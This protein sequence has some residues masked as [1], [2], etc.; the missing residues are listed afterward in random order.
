VGSSGINLTNYNHNHNGAQ[1]VSPGDAIDQQYHLCTSAPNP[2]CNTVGNIPF[3]TPFVGYEPIGL[4]ASDWDGSSNYNSLQITVRHQFSH[5]LSLQGAY[6]WDR[7]LSDVFFGNSANINDALVLR[8]RPG[9]N[10]PKTGQWG[11]VSFDRY[12][13][14]VVNYSYDLPFGHGTQGLENKVIGGWNVAGVTIAQSGN[15]LTFIGGGTGGAYGTNQQLIFQGVTT[16]QFCPGKGNGDIKTP[17]SARSNLNDYFQTTT[18]GC[19]APLV[20]FGGPGATD[21]G[22]SAVG[23]ATGPGQWNWD[24]SIVK[25]TQITER[26]RMQ[27]RTD[28]YNAFNHPQFAP[29]QGGSFGTI[30][31]INVANVTPGNVG[32]SITATTV[33]PRLIQFGLHFFF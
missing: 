9:L 5:G 28:F 12:Q 29:P 7:N 4:Q 3:R 23:I 11:P 13:R 16:A 15:P 25:N 24:I 30:G 17:G 27:F 2:I 18:F 33:N 8:G 1:T 22:N 26:V 31:F 20:P 19:P 21:Y 32:N 10:G 6:T 14:F